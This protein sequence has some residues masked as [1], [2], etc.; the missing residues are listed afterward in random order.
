[1]HKHTLWLLFPSLL[2]A[3]TLT[4]CG[5]KAADAPT[6]GSAPRSKSAADAPADVSAARSK[7]FN[8]TA[9]AKDTDADEEET[10][11]FRLTIDGVRK[12]NAIMTAMKKIDLAKPSQVGTASRQSAA[13]DDKES[14]SDSGSHEPSIDE[15]ETFYN[16][17]KQARAL[18][19][20]QGMDT[21]DFV[22]MT[23]ALLFAGVAQMTIDQGAPDSVAKEMN[24]S[25][26]NLQFYKEHRKELDAMLKMSKS[27]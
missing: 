10:K 18:I 11:R 14:K 22:V 6:A 21:R 25:A 16:G 9:K 20:A 13:A 19:A 7:S 1:M 3:A 15:L 23:N 26:E 24:V 8:V 5:D 17:N 2:L 4:A 12:W 27:K